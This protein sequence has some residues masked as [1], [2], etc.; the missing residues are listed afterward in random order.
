MHRFGALVLF[1]KRLIVPALGSTIILGFFA[2]SMEVFLPHTPGISYLI[3]SLSAQYI[4]FNLNNKNSYYIYF[5]LGLSRRN[6]WVFNFL[7]STLI[8]VILS[9]IAWNIFM[10]TVS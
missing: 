4:I 3:S 5:N 6:L 2:L 7:M 8:A 10:L 9:L 1:Y